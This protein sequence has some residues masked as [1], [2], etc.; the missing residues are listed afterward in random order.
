MAQYDV[1]LLEGGGDNVPPLLEDD[2]NNKSEPK[3][4]GP[5]LGTVWF[6][7]T[8]FAFIVVSAASNYD[9]YRFTIGYRSM[10]ALG[11]YLVMQIGLWHAENKW[12]EEGSAAYLEAAGKDKDSTPE[13]LEAMDMGMVTIPE[14]KMKVAF[15]VPWGFLFGWWIWGVSYL[16]PINGTSEMKPTMFGMV[17]MGVCFFV[18]FVASV[19]MSDAVMNRLPTKKAIL[20]VMF[21]LGWIALG[22]TSSLDV[23]TQLDAQ[24]SPYDQGGVWLL[25]MLGPFTGNPLNTELYLAASQI[26]CPCSLIAPLFVGDHRHLILGPPPFIM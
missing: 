18:S 12:D 8:F 10:I 24:N 20:S 4:K 17:A 26:H 16:F 7:L 22:I 11:G 14:D 1:P 23:T 15:P 25:C 19:P 13:E 9:L 21:L 6:T 3:E 2:V 5:L